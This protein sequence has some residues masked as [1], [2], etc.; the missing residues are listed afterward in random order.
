MIPA[1]KIA[2]KAM[3]RS[4]F[5]TIWH[6]ILNADSTKTLPPVLLFSDFAGWDYLYV[7]Y[8]TFIGCFL[9]LGFRGGLCFSLFT[10]HEPR[11]SFA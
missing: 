3:W 4:V 7:S 9:T 5:L 8:A 2:E 11:L 1:S 10:V 6:R